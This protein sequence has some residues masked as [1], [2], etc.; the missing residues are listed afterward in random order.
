MTRQYAAIGDDGDRTLRLQK[1]SLPSLILHGDADNLVPLQA[2]IDT[3]KNIDESK[4]EILEGWG[5]DLP[6]GTH[7]WIIDKIINQI[8]SH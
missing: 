2:G 4:I 5:H 8:K 7:D 3:H 1:I 6:E